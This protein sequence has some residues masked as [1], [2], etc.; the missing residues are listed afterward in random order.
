[1]I[2]FFSLVEYFVINAAAEA[3]QITY[4]NKIPFIVPWIKKKKERKKKSMALN[5]KVHLMFKKNTINPFTMNTTFAWHIE[6]LQSFFINHI[7]FM[8]NFTLFIY[9]VSEIKL[10]ND[11]YF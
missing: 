11:F 10:A 4:M 9:R 6:C 8:E 7:F 5:F 3:M 1:M 2:F